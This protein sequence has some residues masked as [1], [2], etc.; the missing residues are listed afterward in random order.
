[1]SKL[2]FETY[3]FLKVKRFS[4]KGLSV[5]AITG[6]SSTAVKDAV[7]Q[8]MISLV[9]FTPELL[10]LSKRWRYLLQKVARAEQVIKS[11]GN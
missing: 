6:N 2:I 7:K 1:M 4:E 3:P 9:F 5:A 8:G 11:T 10:L